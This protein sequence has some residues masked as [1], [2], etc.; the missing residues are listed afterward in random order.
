[1]CRFLQANHPRL[2]ADL[3]GV[4]LTDLRE[5][6][7]GIYSVS[8]GGNDVTDIIDLKVLGKTIPVWYSLK[9]KYW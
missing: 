9:K 5:T 4:T 3:L 8:F 2:N 1:M 6:D 7:D